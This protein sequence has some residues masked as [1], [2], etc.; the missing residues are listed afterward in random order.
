MNKKL[1]DVQAESESREGV[2]TTEK[3][4]SDQRTRQLNEEIE[5]LTTSVESG[6]SK[7]R[8]AE[9]QLLFSQDDAADKELRY[10]Q[11]RQSSA[12]LQKRCD[13]A[14][15]EV[16]VWRGKCKSDA[17]QSDAT[18]EDLNAQLVS[19][20]AA[21]A[22]VESLLLS[23]GD[24]DDLERSELLAK[25][26][27]LN[28]ELAS[29]RSAVADR[30]ALAN[31]LKLEQVELQR[32]ADLLD[33][34]QSRV[35]TLEAEL[36]QHST[37]ILASQA[38][39]AALNGRTQ[40]SESTSKRVV[41]DLQ[42][43]IAFL[44][45]S[46]V[47]LSER[48]EHKL[49]E[50]QSLTESMLQLQELLALTERNLEESSQLC[51]ELREQL[52]RE[53]SKTRLLQQTEDERDHHRK[54]FSSSEE[55]A[56]EL[57]AVVSKLTADLSKAQATVAAQAAAEKAL[58]ATDNTGLQEKLAAMVFKLES[59][60]SKNTELESNI[61]FV[62]ERE[63]TQSTALLSLQAT[64]RKSLQ[65]IESMSVQ[66]R[67][68]SSKEVEE[69]E[70][71][72]H[73]LQ[74]GVHIERN[75]HQK[76]L[77]SLH[78]VLKSKELEISTLKGDKV[79]LVRLAEKSSLIP[80]TV[81]VDEGSIG[82]AA[83]SVIVGQQQTSVQRL[84][85][86]L[87]STEGLILALTQALP[88]QVQAQQ[89]KPQTVVHAHVAQESPKRQKKAAVAVSARGRRRLDADNDSEGESERKASSSADY[90]RYDKMTPSGL[91]SVMGRRGAESEL[92]K[93]LLLSPEWPSH[94]DSEVK[95]YP[96]QHRNTAKADSDTR[97]SWSK[98][99]TRHDTVGPSRSPIRSRPRQKEKEKEREKERD[100]DAPQVDTGLESWAL[101]IAR[102]NRF[103]DDLM[104]TLKDEKLS[105][106]KEQEVLGKR[107]AAWRMKKASNP[108]DS[109]GKAELREESSD[110][111]AQTTRLNDAVEQTRVMHGFL[112]ERRRKLDALKEY[113][114]QLSV[115]NESSQRTRSKG[116]QVQYREDEAELT[117]EVMERLGRELDSEAEVTLH[118]YGYSSSVDDFYVGSNA[119][120][121]VGQPDR[122]RNVR[123]SHDPSPT[124]HDR[125]YQQNL[126]TMSQHQNN[127]I[128]G[129]G[130]S[131]S[132]IHSQGGKQYLHQQYPPSYQQQVPMKGFYPSNQGQNSF[133]PRGDLI[134]YDNQYS[135]VGYSHPSSAYLQH[136]QRQG[137]GSGQSQLDDYYMTSS[138]PPRMAVAVDDPARWA[139]P[140]SSVRFNLGI[141]GISGDVS[142][143]FP[144]TDRGVNAGVKDPR[145]IR[146]QLKD[147]TNRRAQ[148]TEA[149]DTHA[150]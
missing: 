124:M 36:Q 70:K 38:E 1:D 87:E 34:S 135:Q 136:R 102:E 27:K 131:A 133:D 77:S 25:I 20:K 121:H 141:K 24:D 14:E 117:L 9:Q 75:Q 81:A 15:S 39:L 64:H 13:E 129:N 19:M 71:E 58:N 47:S 93:D 85:E 10:Q 21:K 94:S 59:L 66:L 101:K 35:A 33:A 88:S 123:Q 44:T 125:L 6:L 134:G 51:N 120:S 126:Q 45:A 67:V 98:I 29:E 32:R 12:A 80:H 5:V 112:T 82:I 49:A 17:V 96:A 142:A 86:K 145:A 106:R 73:S 2:R 100:R 7:C 132:Q 107:R 8:R 3:L 31:S 146:D 78:E 149:F 54:S 116:A 143:S 65:E 79:A 114:L 11:S 128:Q 118:E 109:A 55:N 83:L 43:Q 95:R 63:R 69:K 130:P 16:L 30:D 147:L 41:A 103:L 108:K 52:E 89:S 68:T 150:R 61:K 23:S 84:Q 111:N 50:V 90:H 110:L 92:E 22:V 46:N 42:Q 28:I 119:Y 144:Y 122:H 57:E 18:V 137:S 115:S 60:A 97:N 40:N 53:K 91:G 139:Q 48:V 56:R 138:S 99:P 72:L 105:V 76:V 37:H 104:A 26:S 140:A 62:S 127:A 4:L 148:T 113:M 74:Q